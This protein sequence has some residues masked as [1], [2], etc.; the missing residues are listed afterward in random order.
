LNVQYQIN[1]KLKFTKENLISKSKSKEKINSKTDT[2]DQSIKNI[3][4]KN[5]LSFVNNEKDEKNKNEK[6]KINYLA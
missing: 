6:E 3:F 5:N 4:T 1:E 2:T